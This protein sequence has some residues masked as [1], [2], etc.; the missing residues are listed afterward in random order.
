MT[1]SRMWDL[2]GLRVLIH[3][4]RNPRQLLMEPSHVYAEAP[5]CLPREQLKLIVVGTAKQEWPKAF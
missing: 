1:F 3:V 2:R 5:K 4:S